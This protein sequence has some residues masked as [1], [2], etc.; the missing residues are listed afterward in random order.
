MK[1]LIPICSYIYP[2]FYVE[3]IMALVANLLVLGFGDATVGRKKEKS[4][5]N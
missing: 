5:S 2:V 3:V 1:T 4:V